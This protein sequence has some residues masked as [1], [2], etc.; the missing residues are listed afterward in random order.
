[1]YVKTDK[2]SGT[3]FIFFGAAYRGI[4]SRG[5]GKIDLVWNLWYDSKQQLDFD[6]EL[7]PAVNLNP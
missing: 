3:Q 7:I 1:M 4:C 6:F 2:T 5:K